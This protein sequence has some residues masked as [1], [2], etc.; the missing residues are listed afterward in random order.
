[1]AENTAI[2]PVAAERLSRLRMAM[3]LAAEGAFEDAAALLESPPQDAFGE[4]ERAARSFIS[5]HRI[6][7]E[8]SELSIEEFKASKQELLKKLATIEQQ[9]AAIQRLSAPI[10]DVWDGVVTVP[11]IG[12][13]DSARA[14]DLRER[15]L[16]RIEQ[17][18]T[19]WVILD[20][21]GVDQVDSLITEH[22]IKLTRAVRMM[23]AQCLVTGMRAHMAQML[24]SLGTSLGGLRPILT[25]KDG[26]K[27]CLS[28]RSV[29]GE[30]R[31]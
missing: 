21:T 15:L 30:G 7:V 5:D 18:G 3:A 23:G 24:A 16:A 1:M 27:Y 9:R 28:M 13:W 26:L 17:M 20:L 8:Q 10:I 11:L 19:P 22:L 4:V 29:S 2:V 14:E 31:R 6:A 25:L 12:L